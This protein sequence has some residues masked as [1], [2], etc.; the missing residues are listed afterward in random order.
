MLFRSI[1]KTDV[2]SGFGDGG[3]CGAAGLL[4]GWFSRHGCRWW[5]DCEG[6]VTRICMCLGVTSHIHVIKLILETDKM[7]WLS[8]IMC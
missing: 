6:Q 7:S 3:P 5:L 1:A 2:G 4:G 8:G